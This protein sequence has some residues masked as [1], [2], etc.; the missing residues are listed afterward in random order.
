MIKQLE[1][2]EDDHCDKCGALL[3]LK[4]GVMIIMEYCPVCNPNP[5]LPKGLFSGKRKKRNKQSA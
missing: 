1:I 4:C 3:K 2:F 5:K